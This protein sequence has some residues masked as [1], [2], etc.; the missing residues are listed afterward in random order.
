MRPANPETAAAAAAPEAPRLRGSCAPAP[1]ATLPSPLA[2][3]A[4]YVLGAPPAPPP[5]SP[6]RALGA[7]PHPGRA[8]GVGRA[9]DGCGERWGCDPGRAGCPAVGDGGAAGGKAPRTG[10]GPGGCGSG[11]LG[12]EDAR[13]ARRGAAARVHPAAGSAQR[14]PAPGG[15]WLPSVAAP[16]RTPPVRQVEAQGLTLGAP[17]AIPAKFHWGLARPVS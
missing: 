7:D 6:A 5:G 9:R 16:S 1:A 15:R 17:Y 8:W 10:R 13:G 2:P 11:G 12:R 4:R 3:A 14:L